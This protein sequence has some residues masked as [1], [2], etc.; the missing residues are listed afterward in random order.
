TFFIQEEQAAVACYKNKKG[1]NGM[2][3]NHWK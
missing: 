3:S 2:E 1:R